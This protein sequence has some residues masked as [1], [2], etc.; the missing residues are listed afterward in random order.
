MNFFAV[1]PFPANSAITLGPF[2]YRSTFGS[3]L[4]H[5]LAATCG[6]DCNFFLVVVKRRLL[7][8]FIWYSELLCSSKWQTQMFMQTWTLCKACLCKYM[9]ASLQ[10]S[11]L[12]FFS[13]KIWFWHFIML[14]KLFFFNP[15]MYFTKKLL[16]LKLI[17]LSAFVWDFWWNYSVI[18]PIKAVP[19]GSERQP[20]SITL[21]C[22][23]IGG[24]F[25]LVLN[26][27]NECAVDCSACRREKKRWQESW[28]LSLYFHLS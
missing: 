14:I 11:E 7:Q 6:Q 12:T 23:L 21:F 27:Q 26:R 20:Y 13:C 28:R 18:L 3:R 10:V 9:F 25:S 24:C 8:S 22:L 5:P 2:I 15:K 16:Y 19:E 17:K 1:L 4:H